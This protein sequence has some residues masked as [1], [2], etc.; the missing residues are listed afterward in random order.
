MNKYTPSEV[1][2]LTDSKQRVMRN[3]VNEIKYNSKKT[4]YKWRYAVIAAVLTMSAML[5]VL[6]E[7]F[8]EKEQQPATEIVPDLDL[9]QP[10]FTEEQGLLYLQGVTLGDPQSKVIEYL[11]ENYTTSDFEAGSRA[12]LVLNYDGNAK[13]YLYEDKLDSIVFTKVN[14]NYFDK[15]FNNYAGLKFGTVDDNRFIYSEETSQILKAM[16]APDGSI[17]LYLFYAGPDILENPDYLNAKQNL[18]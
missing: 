10:T 9:T 2:D 14:E 11:G 6:N 18:D 1:K 8:V 16:K 3:V 13:V 4:R 7:T 15:F 5:F 12:D 17:Q